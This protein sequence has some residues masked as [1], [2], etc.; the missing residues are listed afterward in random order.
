M[1]FNV[2]AKKAEGEAE[3]FPLH[4]LYALVFSPRG[5]AAAYMALGFVFVE[6]VFDLQIQRAVVHR[7]AL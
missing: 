6:Y 1:K 4:F 5:Y 2:A 7:Q 3:R